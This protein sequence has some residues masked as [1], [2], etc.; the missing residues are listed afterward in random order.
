MADETTV[1]S[2][3]AEFKPQLQFV[4]M[5]TTQPVLVCSVQ[6]DGLNLYLN[7]MP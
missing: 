6:S 7:R 4:T 2:L 5:E 1:N 3:T